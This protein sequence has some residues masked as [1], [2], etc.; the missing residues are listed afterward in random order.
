M[1]GTYVTLKPL[2]HDDFIIVTN[3][4]YDPIVTEFFSEREKPELEHQLKWF[5]NQIEATDKKKYIIICNKK[6]TKIGLVSLMKIDLLNHNCEIGITIGDTNY[7]GKPH[8]KEAI[9]LILKHCFS[10]LKLNIVYLTVFENNIR[11]IKFF[12]KIGFKNDGIMRQVIFK[13]KKYISLQ[14]MSILEKEFEPQKI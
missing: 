7:W 2:S 14:L 13:N 4:N 8:A 1:N 6:K 9:K 5:R 10:D 3:W 12:K 11:A